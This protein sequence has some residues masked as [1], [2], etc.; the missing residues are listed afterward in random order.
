MPEKTHSGRR[1][2]IRRKARKRKMRETVAGWE[3]Q[4][5]SHWTPTTR[6]ETMQNLALIRSA[7]RRWNADENAED[8]DLEKAA[9]NNNARALAMIVV[10][11]CLVD[12]DPKIALEAVKTLVAME[13]QNQKDEH[14]TIKIEL[15]RQQE[16][17]EKETLPA[18]LDANPEDLLAAKAAI[19]KLEKSG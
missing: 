11:R 16:E 9:A 12:S 15:E 17:E 14:L 18:F 4:A 1:R 10:K 6:T 3:N 2:K 19:E 7:A 5:G 8:Y 13:S